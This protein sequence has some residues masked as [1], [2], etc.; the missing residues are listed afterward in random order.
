M[1][2]PCKQSTTLILS[3]G[4]SLVSHTRWPLH[5]EISN[6]GS[7]EQLDCCRRSVTL[8]PS[9]PWLFLTRKDI[10]AGHAPLVAV[11]STSH[12]VINSYLERG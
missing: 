12:R 10:F 4:I 11:P 9:L 2:P 7:Q 3:L 5:E 8:V 1:L 6:A